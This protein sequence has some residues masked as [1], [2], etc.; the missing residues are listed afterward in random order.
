MLAPLTDTKT[1]HPAPAKAEAAAHLWQRE[2][3]NFEG[4][5]AMLSIAVIGTT[6]GG[7]VFPI[8]LGLAQLALG[9]G[10]PWI[11]DGGYFFSFALLGG[12]V[13]GMLALI[14]GLAALSF[15]AV[16][17]WLSGITPRDVWFAS[18]IGGWTGFFATHLVI[19]G[20]PELG[21]T[22]I[23]GLA[24]VTGQLAA[25]GFVLL[26][27]RRQTSAIDMSDGSPAIRIGLRQL[28]GITTA[29]ALV[30]AFSLALKENERAYATLGVA[31]IYQ[32]A[33]IGVALAIQSRRG[34][35]RFT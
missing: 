30:A 8:V 29:I 25:G 13:G 24:V 16:I 4:V 18:L 22:T 11:G 6:L 5:A 27:R 12:L 26:A 10:Y 34:K 20:L 21:D 35:L 15:A 3:S 14:V 17:A 31:T 1:T 2:P 19:D 32:A 33:V 7:A 23:I 9:T 28:F